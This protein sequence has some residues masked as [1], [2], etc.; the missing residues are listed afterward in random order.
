MMC[1]YPGPAPPGLVGPGSTGQALREKILK[2]R[3]EDTIFLKLFEQLWRL[4]QILGG[5]IHGENPT[6]S[7]TWNHIIVGPA[8]EAN[9]HRTLSP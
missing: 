3:A 7:D 5:H 2:Q 6:G 4:Q 1:G 8:Y 9:F